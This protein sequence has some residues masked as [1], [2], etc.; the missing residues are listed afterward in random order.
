M[1]FVYYVATTRQIGLQTSLGGMYLQS[2]SRMARGDKDG[3]RRQGHGFGESDM[4]DARIT[5]SRDP[6][7]LRRS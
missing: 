6:G 5:S 4:G 1:A 7:W 2:I 3:H